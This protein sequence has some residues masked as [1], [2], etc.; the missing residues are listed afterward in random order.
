[1]DQR[2][3]LFFNCQLHVVHQLFQ[4]IHLSIQPAVHRTHA[5]AHITGSI[6]LLMYRCYDVIRRGKH[7][8]NAFA[9]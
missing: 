6:T 1:M 5:I 7:V 4:I 3:I 2:V 8:L 9:Y